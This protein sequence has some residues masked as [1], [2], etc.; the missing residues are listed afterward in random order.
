[1]VLGV[2]L[3]GVFMTVA[4][5]AWG[6]FGARQ[7]QAG[8]RA[9]RYAGAS[10]NFTVDAGP[11]SQG[12]KLP[13][14]WEVFLANAGVEWTAGQFAFVIALHA[15]VGFTL[16]TFAGLALPAALLAVGFLFFK[17]KL[18][19][20]KRID[21]MSEQL[22][23]ALM[24]LGSALKSGLG[25][26]QALQMVA[27]ESSPPLAPEFGRLGSDLMMGLNAESAFA[28]LES[29]LASTEGEMLCAAL[30][31]QRQTGGNLSEIL[32]NLQTTI[33][34][35]QHVKGQIKALTAEGR[36]S[37]WVL[38]LLPIFVGVAL[39]VLNPKYIMPLFTDTRGL[40]AVAVMILLIGVGAFWIS[41]IV[42]IKY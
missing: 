15:M 17:L 42:K 40:A 10:A 2:I 38:T 27:R 24:M 12:L 29:R 37:G 18:K 9:L 6:L 21:K 16:G 8:E 11:S 26:Q 36:M 5:L 33:R 4:A 25:F 34:D 28:R 31:V 41:R 14:K 19:Q 39:F 13:K 1:M 22:P 23:D 32:N 35:R 7:S 20:A 30:L 3:F